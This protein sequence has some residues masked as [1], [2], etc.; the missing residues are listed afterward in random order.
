VFASRGWMRVALLFNLVGT[1]L[2]F[3]A[4][5]AT[6]SNINIVQSDDGSTTFCIGHSGF[7][8]HMPD[9]RL[10][11]L[12]EC[13]PPTRGSRPISVVNIEHPFF[14]TLGFLFTVM[15]FTIQILALPSAKTIAQMQAEVRM[16]RKQIKLKEEQQRLA[17]LHLDR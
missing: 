10:G 3:F 17:R 15:G 8:R 2:L 9:G 14:V 7:I 13:P 4:F 6:S 5:Q 12:G 1:A 11:L 16:V